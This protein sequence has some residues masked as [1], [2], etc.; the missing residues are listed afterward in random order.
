MNPRDVQTA[1]PPRS[2]AAGSASPTRRTHG[3]EKGRAGTKRAPSAWPRL[4]LLAGVTGAVFMASVAVGAADLPLREVLA[5]L[6]GGGSESSRAIVLE[7][8]VPRAVVAAL[9]GAD[10]KSTL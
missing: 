6:S 10:R 8:R 5:A 4:L 2:R 1:V 7:L 9:V 3:S